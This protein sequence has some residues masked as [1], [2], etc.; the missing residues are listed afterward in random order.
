MDKEL[1]QE[2]TVPYNLEKGPL[3]TGRIS[4]GELVEEARLRSMGRKRRNYP[5]LLSILA[6]VVLLALWVLAF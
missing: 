6:V 2:A 4:D 5:I 3:Q 1:P